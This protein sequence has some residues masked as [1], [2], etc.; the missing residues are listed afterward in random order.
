MSLE[1]GTRFVV[2]CLLWSYYEFLIK[3]HDVFTHVIQVTSLASGQTYNIPHAK[4]V[5]LEIMGK[6]DIAPD[7][8]NTLWS[9]NNDTIFVAL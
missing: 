2:I 9:V 4:E 6:I 5:I 3:L 7:Y 1:I 8:S